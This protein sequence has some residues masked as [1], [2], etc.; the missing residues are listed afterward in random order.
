MNRNRIKTILNNAAGKNICVIGDI[1]L[2]RYLLGDVKR[3]SPE[4]PVQV[5][6]IKKSEP[7][8]GGAANVCLNIKA[9]G[10]NPII[11]GVGGY[12]N[13]F[14]ELE[15]IFSQLKIETSGLI[16]DSKRLT[17]SKTRIIADSHHLL[18]IDS[19]TV[20]PV[21]SDMEKKIFQFLQKNSGKFEFI[22][23][24][25]YNKGVLT[26]NIIKGL[27]RFSREN[28]KKI[29]VDPKF[30]NF[31]EYKN[32]FLFKPNKKEIEDAFGIK[33]K[34]ES[35]MEKLG[36]RLI[37]QIKC[38]NLVLT[39]GEKGMLFFEKPDGKL[40]I[41]IMKTKARKVADVSGAGDT[42][43]STIA[44][45]LAG[46]ATTREAVELANIAAGLV[47]EEVGIVPIEKERLINY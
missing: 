2:D 42:V 28:S 38:K 34:S 18:R 17:T 43:I 40:K 15:Y 4:A 6:N 1:M 22:V 9:L 35:D 14:E 30:E 47:V 12:D 16:K 39:L 8:L 23:V 32:V 11:I 10:A 26:K 29:L 37:K 27:T 31:F 3:I 19:E 5:F 13:D 36:R 44:V 7:K 25:D 21:D 46:N 33:V 20:D 41:D 45:A 24:Q